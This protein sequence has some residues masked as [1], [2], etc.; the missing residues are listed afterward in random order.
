[1]NNKPTEIKNVT[2]ILSHKLYNSNTKTK[3]EFAILFGSLAST[4]KELNEDLKVQKLNTLPKN[5]VVSDKLDEIIKKI[6]LVIEKLDN[7]INTKNSKINNNVNNTNYNEEFDEQLQSLINEISLN[8]N[9]NILC[10]SNKNECSKINNAYQEIYTTLYEGFDLF[11]EEVDL[12]DF[13]DKLKA[14]ISKLEETRD[15]IILP[16]QKAGKATKLYNGHKYIIRLGSRGGKYILV[17]GFK[18]YI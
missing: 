1:M 18:K 5:I 15:S 16:T 10:N 7:I 17:K 13:K 11:D 2:S 14:S 8:K 12:D 3:K 6:K 9:G 4:S